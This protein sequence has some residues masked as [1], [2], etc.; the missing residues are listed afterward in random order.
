MHDFRQAV[1]GSSLKHD[2]SVI[3]H[4]TPGIQ[5]VSFAIKFKQRIGHNFSASV[6]LQVTGAVACIQQLFDL[7][8]VKTLQPC[9]LVFRKFASKVL[10]C[11]DDVFAF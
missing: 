6:I 9:A 5:V 2:M 11:P 10:C 8:G 7:L 1:S 4:D 3:G